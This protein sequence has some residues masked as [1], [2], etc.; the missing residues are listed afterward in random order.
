VVPGSSWYATPSIVIATAGGIGVG[1]V[2]GG[3]VQPARVTA[4]AKP[5]LKRAKRTDLPAMGWGIS[6]NRRR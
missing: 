4:I 6:F 1:V 2:A 5:T 3:D